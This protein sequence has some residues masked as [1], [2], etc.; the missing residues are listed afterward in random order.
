M[1]ESLKAKHLRQLMRTAQEL[2]RSADGTEDAH[3][4]GLFLRAAAAVEHRAAEVANAAEDAITEGD[5]LSF[6]EALEAAPKPVDL[7]V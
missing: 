2:R 4:V 6:N 5:E 3:Y 1:G 7:R